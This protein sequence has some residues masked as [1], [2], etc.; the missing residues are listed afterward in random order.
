MTLSYYCYPSLLLIIK[1]VGDL[2]EGVVIRMPRK[3]TRKL[4]EPRPVSKDI[5]VA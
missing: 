2:R 1:N 4:E 5:T 3:L